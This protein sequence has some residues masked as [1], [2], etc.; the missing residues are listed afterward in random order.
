VSIE[1]TYAVTG[2][3]VETL[4]GPFVSAADATTTTNGLN[5]AGVLNA[6]STVPATKYAAGRL[7]LSSGS[8][9]L[10]LTALPGRTADEV[11]D[12][13]GLKLQ[14]LILHAKSD[15]ANPITATKG[16]SNGYGLNAAGGTWTMTLDPDT[17]GVRFLKDAAPDIDSTHKT[18]DVSGTGS[19]VL[20][21]EIVMG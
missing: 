11:V 12:G 6:S 18:I 19:Q 7:T 20:D 13:T 10:D 5:I 21:Y 4:T 14:L 16:A 8:G 1:V 15:N 9:T 3:I 2:T 17:T